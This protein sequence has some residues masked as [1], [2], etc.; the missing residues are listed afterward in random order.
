MYRDRDWLHDCMDLDKGGI[1]YILKYPDLPQRVPG[2]VRYKG[3]LPG[4]PGIWFG[5]ELTQV[6]VMFVI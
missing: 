2:R 4:K 1:V 5:V 3:E 6:G